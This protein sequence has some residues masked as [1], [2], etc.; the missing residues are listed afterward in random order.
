MFWLKAG[1]LVSRS[2]DYSR[3]V[4]I[5]ILFLMIQK[6]GIHL[7]QFRQTLYLL[8]KFSVGVISC[9]LRKPASFV[10]NPNAS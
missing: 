2:T 5:K 10:K 4:F 7:S 1:I 6:D 3:D 9:Q 8:S